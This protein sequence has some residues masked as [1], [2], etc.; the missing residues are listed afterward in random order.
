MAGHHPDRARV[1]RAGP[2]TGGGESGWPASTSARGDPA[3]P[4]PAATS[5]GA[6]GPTPNTAVRIAAP[7][8]RRD[9]AVTPGIVP[10]RVAFR[11][12]SSALSAVPEEGEDDEGRHRCQR[13]A[14]QEEVPGSALAGRRGG[15]RVGHAVTGTW[16]GG[17]RVAFRRGVGFGHGGVGRSGRPR[18]SAWCGLLRRM[19]VNST[20]VAVRGKDALSW[21]GVRPALGCDSPDTFGIS[22][23][24]RAPQRPGQQRQRAIAHTDPRQG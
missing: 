8:W 3:A 9:R 14:Q 5:S 15:G 4:T 22:T 11:N 10:G 1:P 18:V 13:G 17:C 6:D 16:A 23:T 21:Q 19:A 12:L 7:C 20:Q 24:L 2:A